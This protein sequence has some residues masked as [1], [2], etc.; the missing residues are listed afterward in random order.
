MMAVNG[1]PM[2]NVFQVSSFCLLLLMLSPGNSDAQNGKLCFEHLTVNQGL[3]NNVVYAMLQDSQGYLWFATDNGLNKYDGYTFTT[4][5]K[6][7]GDATSLTGNAVLQL[8]EDQDGHIWIGMMGQGICKFDRH[9]ETFTCYSP[10]PLTLTQGTIHSMSEDQGGYLWVCNQGPELR[11]FDK[12]TGQYSRFNYASLLASTSANGKSII[13][14]VNTIYRDKMG[15][16]WVCSA[17]GLHRMNWKPAGEGKPS[18]VSFTS[19]RHDPADARS[20]SHDQVWEIY[21]DHAGM[22]WVSTYQGLN[23]FDRKT[24]TFTPCPCLLYTSPSPRD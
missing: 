16:I 2:K 14:V 13:P 3:A 20:I 7:P 24:G 8:M 23:R 10:N 1:K 18:Q 21:E 15:T 12:Q 9:T 19:Y 17:K 11:R 4:Y 22:L 5:K 6:R